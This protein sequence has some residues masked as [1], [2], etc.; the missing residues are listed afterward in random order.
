MTGALYRSL[1]RWRP[2]RLLPAGLARRLRRRVAGMPAPDVLAALDALTGAGV[3]VVLAG[4]W[5]VDALLGRQTR[6]HSDVDLVV[7]PVVAGVEAA[8]QALAPLGYRVVDDQ[9][10]GGAWAPV[11]VVLRNSTGRT[12]E[13]LAS[14]RRPDAVAGTLAGR[15]VSCL[16]AQVQLDYHSG[17]RA[18]REDR[19]DV[20]HLRQHLAGA[21]PAPGS[22]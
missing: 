4:G 14:D 13:L 3:D 2:G 16:S 7:T 17:Y 10:E 15:P 19:R 8:A 5:G 12:V 22:R 6:R 21:G 1:G 9:A 11:V 18:T 20:A